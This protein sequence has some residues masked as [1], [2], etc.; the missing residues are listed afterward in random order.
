MSLVW[1]RKG[2]NFVVCIDAVW[3]ERVIA[4]VKRIM[5]KL[6]PRKIACKKIKDQECKKVYKHNLTNKL[7]SSASDCERS[8]I[9]DL[10][11]SVCKHHFD[12]T[13]PLTRKLS[14]AR[15]NA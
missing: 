8:T 11:F 14:F 5:K 3:H 10:V 4:R 7:S 15:L 9:Y 13:K 2:T 12:V 1:D 6:D